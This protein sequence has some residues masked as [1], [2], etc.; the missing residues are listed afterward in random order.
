MNVDVRDVLDR[1]VSDAPAGDWDLDEVVRRGRAVR[2]RRRRLLAGGAAA[3]IVLGIGAAV[4]LPNLT[5]SSE[6]IAPSGP[7]PSVAPPATT[8]GPVTETWRTQWLLA[9]KRV[10]GTLHRLGL[11]EVSPGGSRVADAPAVVPDASQLTFER[12]VARR[13]YLIVVT[14]YRQP[15]QPDDGMRLCGLVGPACELDLIETSDTENELGSHRTEY[16][17][18]APTH[19]DA[20]VER[21]YSTGATVSVVLYSEDDPFVDQLGSAADRR[22]VFDELLDAVGVPDLSGTQP[23]RAVTTAPD[24]R[25]SAAQSQAATDL[26]HVQDSAHAAHDRELARQQPCRA[27]DLSATAHPVEGGTQTY[28]DLLTFTNTS[29]TAC[30]LAGTPTVRLAASESLAFGY[31]KGQYMLALPDLSDE[32]VLVRPGAAAYLY[33]SKFGCSETTVAIARTAAVTV[34][35]GEVDVRLPRSGQGALALCGP[36]SGDPGNLV[37]VTPFQPDGPH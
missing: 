27:G 13:S 16:F 14:A 34:G 17:P 9:A 21:L 6:R 3:A 24:P 12:L 26:G 5:T 32:P 1:A 23:W 19:P 37:R 30:G 4:G 35:D 7:T 18:M 2:I 20:A 36:A 33:L 22:A 31:A 10:D 29:A 28:A 25:T 11:G 15:Q 8:P